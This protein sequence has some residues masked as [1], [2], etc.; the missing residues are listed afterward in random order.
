MLRQFFNT[1]RQLSQLGRTVPLKNKNAQ[2]VKHSSENILNYSERKSSWIGTD[3]REEI[4]NEIVSDFL[5]KN[6]FTR[7]CRFTLTGTVFAD[8][9]IRTIGGFL[10]NTV[11]DKIVANWIDEIK[12]IYE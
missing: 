10:R 2:T 5:I 9:F 12:F 1:N 7:Y 4:L 6:N 3:H 11:F 8:L